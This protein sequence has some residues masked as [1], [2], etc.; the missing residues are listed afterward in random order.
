MK[1]TQNFQKR[2]LTKRRLTKRRLTKR[3]LTKRRLTKR[4]LTK[5]RLTKRRL[6]KRRSGVDDSKN[7]S[8]LTVS[9]QNAK[10]GFWNFFRAVSNFE[11]NETIFLL[12]S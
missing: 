8:T 2:R 4:H 7:K 3:R 10:I 9:S 11:K 12:H 1:G 6:T 5:R